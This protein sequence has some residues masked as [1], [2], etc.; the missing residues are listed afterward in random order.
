MIVAG[1]SACP[2]SSNKT[3]NDVIDIGNTMLIVQYAKKIAPVRGFVR[4]GGAPML[5]TAK[6]TAS[7]LPVDYIVWS[8]PIAG[9][10]AASHGGGALWITGSASPT[11]TSQLA[12][13]SWTVV[14]KA[15][16]RLGSYPQ[17]A[18]WN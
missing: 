4:V 2:A 1:L 3:F 18:G 13:L 14:P 16:A 15:G 17:L 9:I 6:G 5:M 7:I 11:A 10:A 12:A 8:A